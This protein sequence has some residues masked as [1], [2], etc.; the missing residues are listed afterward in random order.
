VVAWLRK[1]VDYQRKRNEG[2][3]LVYYLTMSDLKMVED[4]LVKWIQEVLATT[5]NTKKMR[6]TKEGYIK[7]R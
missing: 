3:N 5:L 6:A 2:I 1:C 4:T 7:Y